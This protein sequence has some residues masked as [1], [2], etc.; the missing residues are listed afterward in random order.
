MTKSNTIPLI[1]PLAACTVVAALA[2]L[3]YAYDPADLWRWALS[4]SFLLIAWSVFE[5]LFRGRRGINEIRGSVVL[6]AALLTVTLGFSALDAAGLLGIEGNDITRRAYGVGVGVLLVV[7]G[8]F[9]PKQLEPL[10]EKQCSAAAIQSLQRFAGWVFV[11]AG[12]G[13][14]GAWLVLPLGPADTVSTTLCISAVVLVFGRWM[15][16][17]AKART[18]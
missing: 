9:V 8:N 2:A 7:I 18:N 1:W 4:G 6:A 16:I 3:N 10:L 17:S 15:L 12:L 5:V 13:Y 14:A 11:L